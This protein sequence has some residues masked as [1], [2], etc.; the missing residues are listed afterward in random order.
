MTTNKPEYYFSMISKIPRATHH[1]EKMADYIEQ[2]AI[3]RHLNYRRDQANNIIITAEASSDYT[4]HEPII[5]QGHMDMVAAKEK[6]S[7]HDFRKD[8]LQLEV[9][10]GYLSAKETT[11]GADDGV[12]IAYM[13]S[14]LDDNTLS[15][16]YLTCIFTTGEE[17]DFSGALALDLSN[18]K[19][20]RFISLDEC[21]FGVCCVSSLGSQTIDV[22]KKTKPQKTNKHGYRLSV[23]GLLGGHSGAD[24]VKERANAIMLL[25][26]ALDSLK[27]VQISAITADHLKNVIPADGEV[28]FYTP[29][30]IKKLKLFF[31]DI[32]S[33]YQSSDPNITFTLEDTAISSL[34]SEE[35]TKDLIDFLTL[36]PNGT[37]TC[38]T[39][40]PHYPV[41][42]SNVASIYTYQNEI[43]C[44][45][46]YRSSFKS[47][48]QRLLR[49][50]T[51]LAKLTHLTIHASL[52]EDGWQYEES[53]PLRDLLQK[54]FRNYFNQDLLLSAAPG[55]LET[56][57]FKAKRPDLQI[58]TLGPTIIDYHTPKE[59]LDLTTFNQIYDFLIYF[60]EKV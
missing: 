17:I 23:N 54:E 52:D 38:S 6:S 34:I 21:D 20:H 42:S 39:I 47:M 4:D 37:I 15:H 8:P 51:K 24:I 50:F 60:L 48:R 32:K 29:D 19:G 36:I 58:V 22:V 27:H 40:I 56:A 33:E 26:R 53:N 14:I 18:I 13:L 45:V 49:Q 25:A 1:E 31:D 3:D 57:V 41:L 9:K 55:G 10:D 7:H 5:L 12:A 59:R 30:D 43:I 11:L 16:P 35:D 46:F 44:T 2:F 28:T